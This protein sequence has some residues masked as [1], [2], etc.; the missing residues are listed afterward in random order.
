MDLT[1][2][3]LI[4]YPERF[5][6]TIWRKIKKALRRFWR[7]YKSQILCF[8]V[9]LLVG[10]IFLRVGQTKQIAAMEQ[11]LLEA[12]TVEV[13]KEATAGQIWSQNN[14]DYMALARMIGGA[15]ERYNLSDDACRALIDICTNRKNANYDVF[16]NDNTYKE[17]VEHEGQFENVKA[18]GIYTKSDYELCKNYLESS[19]GRILNSDKF[20]WVKMDQGY[21]IA[22]DYDA[23]TT[24]NG[25]TQKV[26]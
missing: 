25:N 20:F 5:M 2:T 15:R 9:G 22:M 12:Q 6:K 11:R 26:E 17:V 1:I 24:G 16:A 10:L 18:E 14:Q 7:E 21:I 13:Q 19:S 3:N 23:L 4:N 8:A